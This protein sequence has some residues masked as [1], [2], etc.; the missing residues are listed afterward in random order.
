MP[1]FAVPADF[2]WD[3]I[4]LKMVLWDSLAKDSLGYQQN[5]LPEG[6]LTGVPM[7]LSLTPLHASLPHQNPLIE[8]PT[9][10]DKWR[11]WDI[12]ELTRRCGGNRDLIIRALIKRAPEVELCPEFSRSQFISTAPQ[13]YDK[14]I[15]QNIQGLESS[16]CHMRT[17]EKM[18]IYNWKRSFTS[19]VSCC[20]SPL[21]LSLQ[22][23]RHW[24]TSHWS[25]LWHPNPRHFLSQ[26]CLTEFWGCEL[27][28]VWHQSST[29]D[30][31]LSPHS[32]LFL[33]SM[34]G[35][36]GVGSQFY[37][38]HCDITLLLVP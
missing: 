33:A 26:D 29:L 31:D 9:R 21:G 5:W 15:I 1:V 7:T 28:W 37:L 38:L 20:T 27:A 23:Y 34:E 19:T 10:C 12:W 4:L 11:S 24:F 6:L 14:H 18:T 30:G 22:T 2:L 8:I 13:K 17:S 3:S 36:L 16:L 32:I 25:L 35:S